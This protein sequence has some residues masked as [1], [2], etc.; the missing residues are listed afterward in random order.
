MASYSSSGAAV[1]WNVRALPGMG[2]VFS[3]SAAPAWFD[4]F[5]VL[6]WRAM[7]SRVALTPGFPVSGASVSRAW[8]SLWAWRA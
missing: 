5:S 2:G 4:V 1:S 6:P 7:V 8:V 3:L